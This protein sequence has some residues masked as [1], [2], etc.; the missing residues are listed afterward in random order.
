MEVGN[1]N[2]KTF[3]LRT[4]AAGS[5]VK[6]SM[7]SCYTR[8]PG[9][10]LTNLMTGGGGGGLTVVHILYPKKSQLLYLSTPKKSLLLLAYP[11]KSLCPF[12]A[13]PKNPC[14]FLLRPKKIPASFIDPKNHFGP[15]FQ[16]QKNHSESPVIQICEWGPWDS[17][18]KSNCASLFREIIITVVPAVT[19]CTV[20]MYVSCR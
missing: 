3:W 10:P 7:H 17:N 20:Q 16:T 6:N 5:P 8:T 14:F 15:K 19:V 18:T 12:F 13:T 11:K 9:A 2:L 1:Q 4:F